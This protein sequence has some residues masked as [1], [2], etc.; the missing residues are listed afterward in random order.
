MND[1]ATPRALPLSEASKD[2]Q[3]HE[4]AC[5]TA[6][7]AALEQDSAYR[8][9]QRVSGRRITDIRLAGSFPE[10]QVRMTLHYGPT[11][12]GQRELAFNVWKRLFVHG[13]GQAPDGTD[14]VPAPSY[15]G[16]NVAG[17]A[18]ES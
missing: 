14:R 5:L 7:Q 4:Q 15:F 12:G 1:S 11:R 18:L 8:E 9:I 2:P 3:A 6:V 17:W 10:T 13:I 16:G